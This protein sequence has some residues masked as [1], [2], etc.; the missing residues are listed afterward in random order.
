[1]VGWPGCRGGVVVGIVF[2]SLPEFGRALGSMMTVERGLMTDEAG[3]DVRWVDGGKVAED[4]EGESV[5]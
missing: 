2:G 1:M 4:C 3:S 5:A